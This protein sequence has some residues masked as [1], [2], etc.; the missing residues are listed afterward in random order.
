MG[1]EQRG[2]GPAGAVSIV[3]DVL[4]VGAVAANV[5]LFAVSRPWPTSSGVWRV[6]L[7]AALL[8]ALLVFALFLVGASRL[9]RAGAVA[10]VT[11]ALAT[12]AV[13]DVWFPAL[14][15]CGR[16]RRRGDVEAMVV[17]TGDE[18]VA[19]CDVVAEYDAHVAVVSTGED[20]GGALDGRWGS[21][22]DVAIIPQPSL[23]RD[24]A[25][26]GHTCPVEPEATGHIPADWNAFGQE[27]Q[28]GERGRQRSY[29]AVVK[30]SLKSVLWYRLDVVA[31]TDG[32]RPEDW[33]WD[34][35]AA[36]VEGHVDDTRVD[37]PLTF[38][39]GSE[40][41][42]GDWF[43]NQL[44]GTDPQL[45]DDLLKGEAP[46]WEDP[47][48][49]ATMTRVLSDM[50]AIWD[51]DPPFTADAEADLPTWD[52]L[53]GQVIEGA[54]GIMFGPSFMLNPIAD[55]AGGSLLV[56]VGFPALERGRP[57]VVG[58][59]F[60]VV[61]EQEGTCRG[62]SA[63]HALT[64]WL[65]GSEALR[66]WS[67]A[68]PGF[69]SPS[70]LSPH[71]QESSDDQVRHL[72]TTQLRQAEAPVPED[73]GTGGA[74]GDLLLFDLSDDQLGSPED[75]DPRA[76]WPVLER[77]FVAV[78][79]EPDDDACAVEWALARLEEVYE[80]VAP[81]SDAPGPCA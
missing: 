2:A 54:A 72:L 40:W 59:D 9:A 53:P 60:A 20:I 74:G 48:I 47:A 35:L 67:T 32:P 39:A 61:P 34:D 81:D 36:W 18:L 1:G 33:T 70:D 38:A 41:S 65:T 11:V 62:S 37:V 75:G 42:I 66:L 76:A 46:D 63:G 79:E 68:D 51:Q 14:D 44:A 3:A 52:R 15:D 8:G 56:P 57:F 49:R 58:A 64:T 7:G 23:V 27:R 4:A 25:A 30:G 22:P 69:L 50:A 10:V 26:D 78:A 13:V 31:A 5:V 45:Y 71:A 21:P 19:F 55:E 12:M 29:G 24:Y 28:G 73:D 80:G 77:F 17:W 16:E 43:E 6:A